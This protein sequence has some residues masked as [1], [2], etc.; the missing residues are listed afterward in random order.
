[1]TCLYQ[2]EECNRVI[3]NE[4][5]RPIPGWEGLYE[6][7]D[8][9]RVRR[10]A[11]ARGT[12]VGHIVG[13]RVGNN[14]YKS[15][16]LYRPRQNKIQNGTLFSTHR[17]IALTFCQQGEGRHVDHIN[18]DKLDNRAENLRWVTPREN[19]AN[20]RIAPRDLHSST[21]LP[22]E[23][24]RRLL[25]LSPILSRIE[26]AKLFDISPRQVRRLIKAGGNIRG[27]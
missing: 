7:S 18:G 1:M 10:V 5:W 2:S 8:Q 16:S 9:G 14:G 17:L 26:L 23:G 4:T 11:L 25:E 24:V 3:E 15:C 22:V 21:R 20:R 19:M 13:Y 6:A 27:L 12:H